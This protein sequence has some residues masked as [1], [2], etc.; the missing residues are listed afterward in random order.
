MKYL[1]LVIL[2]INVAYSQE[3]ENT[4]LEDLNGVVER[5][6]T[7]MSKFVPPVVDPKK[8]KQTYVDVAQQ[9]LSNSVKIAGTYADREVLKFTNFCLDCNTTKKDFN[10]P[11][12][13][14][15]EKLK[16]QQSKNTTVSEEIDRFFLTNKYMDSTNST[17]VKITTAMKYSTMTA[18]DPSINFNASVD[19]GLSQK[20]LQLFIN[21]INDENF[22][23][24]GNGEH[25]TYLDPQE[26]K[27]SK[28]SIGLQMLMPK[29][30]K[31]NTKTMVGVNG[32]DAF[33]SVRFDRDFNVGDFKMDV[34]ESIKYSTRD[35]LQDKTELF[36]DH[37]VTKKS[38]TRVYF[39][40]F[41][42]HGDYGMGYTAA[43]EYF[44][45]PNK[46]SGFSA[47]AEADGNTKF[48][49]TYTG[50]SPNTT[51]DSQNMIY[52]YS[53]TTSLRQNFYRKWLYYQLTPAV[54]WNKN[55]S[56]Q[57]EYIVQLSFDFYFGDV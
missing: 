36:I 54:S 52:N 41:E 2:F 31:I 1:L 56:F 39:N 33:T 55:N 5:M 23:N 20:R 51:E 4:Y 40:R 19:L 16:V 21:N 14:P 15:C 7:F 46:F 45:N 11:Y 29:F 57:A 44:F 24:V 38:L 12:C 34:V 53:V 22:D 48:K 17:Y 30:L 28:Q 6:V 13:T 42:N 3:K 43:L 47:S 18:Y 35:N 27:H 49:R 25:G 9:D 26:S 37:A 32:F 50:T 10:E 8:K